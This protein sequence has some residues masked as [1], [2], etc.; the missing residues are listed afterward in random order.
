AATICCGRSAPWRWF[1]SAASASASA[2]V[3]SGCP[4][5]AAVEGVLEGGGA[6]APIGVQEALATAGAQA[7]IGVDHR[8]DG[9]ADFL[10]GEA[11]A[12]DLADGGH[13]VAGAAERDLVEFVTLL[14]D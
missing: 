8:F 14:L 2:G 12:D 10:G 9:A 7:E 5:F 3:I 11:T 6:D 1:S 13:L 4:G